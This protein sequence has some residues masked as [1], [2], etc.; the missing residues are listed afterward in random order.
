MEPRQVPRGQRHQQ[1]QRA[2]RQAEPDDAA[3]DAE[4]DAFEQQLT[5]NPSR[6][7]AERGTNRQF[8]LPRLGS[9][10][11]QVRDV[12]ARDEEDQPDRPH[13]D[14]QHRSH[15]ADEIVLE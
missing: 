12:R 4:R 5:G 11:E 2:K 3:Q 7:G 8:L 10:E 13:Q 14:P 1:P 9:H 15:V 6:A